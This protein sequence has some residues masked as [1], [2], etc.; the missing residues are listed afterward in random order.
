MAR[1]VADILGELQPI[2]FAA[3]ARACDDSG[4]TSD[5]RQSRGQIRELV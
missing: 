1:T 3:V 5:H 2:F 4:F